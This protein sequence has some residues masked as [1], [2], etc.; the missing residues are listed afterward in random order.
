MNVRVKFRKYGNLRFIGHLDTMRS[1]QQAIRRA[2]LDV[3]Y[4][5][6]FTPHMIMSFAQP[7]GVGLESDGEYMDIRV[8]STP[9]SAEA[10]RLLNENRAEGIE[11]LSWRELPEGSKNAMS[12][13]AAADYEVR[14]REDCEPPEGWEARLASFLLRPE[15]LVHKETKK[16]AVQEMDI[17]PWVYACEV[18]DGVIFLTVSTGSA[19]NLKP[20]LLLQAF[21]EQEEWEL[22]RFALL[23]TRKEIYSDLGAEGERKFFSLEEL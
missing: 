19:G 2:G 23:V 6:G 12:I 3:C 8:N 7:L 11:V 10:V 22:S 21:A 14:F 5:E 16:K 13:V 9:S 20:E 4:S 15:I 17:R 1:L 18:R